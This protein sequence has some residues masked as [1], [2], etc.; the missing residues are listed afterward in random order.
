MEKIYK[1]DEYCKCINEILN[2]MRKKRKDAVSS[3]ELQ[4]YYDYYLDKYDEEIG[5]E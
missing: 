1:Y 4:S 5:N 3:L 2:D